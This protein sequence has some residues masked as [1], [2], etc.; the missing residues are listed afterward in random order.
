MQLHG[1]VTDS[2]IAAE[3]PVVTIGSGPT[4]GVIGAQFIGKFLKYDNIITMDMGGTSFDIGVIVKG[5]PL[6]RAISVV[7]GYHIMLPMIDVNSIGAGGGSIAHVYKGTLGVGPQS[8]G[9]EPGPA[10]YGRDGM[11]PTI[12]DA[13][14]ILGYIRGTLATDQIVLDH[15][16]SY[17]AI[18]EHV[19]HK[20]NMTVEEAAIGIFDLANANMSNAIRLSTI[21]RGYN[22]TEFVAFVY[23]GAGP[24]HASVLCRNLGIKKMVIPWFA[25]TF[26]AFGV[27]TSL[28]KHNYT[29]IVGPELLY[30][31][32]LDMV[33]EKLAEMENE[34][35]ETLKRGGIK[36]E[37][38]KFKYYFDMRFE[39]Q[40][41][42]MTVEIPVVR[43]KDKDLKKIEDLFR[44]RYSITYA[45]VPD[46]PC[47]VVSAKVEVS[48][49]LFDMP[50]KKYP[51]EGKDASHAIKERREVYFDEKKDFLPTNVYDGRKII[52]GNVI[53]D[54]A[55]IEY[56]D[57][58][59]VVRPGQ[60]AMC[61]EMKNIVI[62]IIGDV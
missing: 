1:G 25:S 27:A 24:C 22:P 35:T 43:V 29:S 37:K 34:G 60:K 20:L 8:A 61:D 56:P 50:I 31:L 6:R 17:K 9:S 53:D 45:Y 16:A 14:V 32:N 58:V 2:S 4:G 47:E 5:E 48:G 11:L 23:G 54:Y 59:I 18:K 15:K 46:Y 55:I 3:K 12:T 33:N 42:E 36:T 40:L 13:N 44:Q 38:M 30:D 7:E 28:F 19:A 41:N 10:C 39:G 49:S 52:P 62:E 51:L 57:T 26:S 21:E